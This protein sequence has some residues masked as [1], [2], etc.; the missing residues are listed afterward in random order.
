MALSPFTGALLG[1]DKEFNFGVSPGQGA[2]TGKLESINDYFFR[3]P[4]KIF[5]EL[6][7]LLAQKF[8]TFFSR[9]DEFYILPILSVKIMISVED[10]YNSFPIKERSFASVRLYLNEV[11]VRLPESYDLYWNE[12]IGFYRTK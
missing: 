5:K 8:P 2:W 10:L 11:D 12:S 7:Q 6:Q 3:D 1:L 4:K 9:P